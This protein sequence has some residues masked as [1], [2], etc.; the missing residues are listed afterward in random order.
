[1]IKDAL[2]RRGSSD[3]ERSK[4]RIGALAGTAVLAAAGG[5]IMAAGP[6]SAQLTTTCVGTADSVTIPGDL[7]V[8][9]NTTCELTNVTVTGNAKVAAGANLIISN[10]TLQG[11]VTVAAN[12]YFDSTGSSVAGNVRLNGAYGAYLDTSTLSTSVVS[13]AGSDDS[14]QTFV[15][16]TG[17]N[18]AKGVTAKTGDNLLADSTV[19]TAVNADGVDYFDVDNSTVG[20]KLTVTGAAEG[21]AVTDSE[22]YGDVTYTGNSTVIQLGGDAPVATSTGSN[23]FDKNVTI[24]DNTADITLVQN[25]IRGDLSGTGNDPAPTLGDGNRVRGTISGQF[26]GMSTES[27]AGSSK[28]STLASTK[29]ASHASQLQSQVSQRRGAAENAAAAAG[30]ARVAS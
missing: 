4:R 9:K 14:I 5:V 3:G 1:M 27:L 25:I 19:G 30:P 8:A 11:T 28:V 20:G 10:S 7:V 12:G 15:Y 6:A 16:L 26:G 2:T 13:N 23:Y 24:S 17:S 21:S 18:V 22:V 29:S